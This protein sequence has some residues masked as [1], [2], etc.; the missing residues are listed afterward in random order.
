MFF[1]LS[2]VVSSFQLPNITA[3]EN[4]S[5]EVAVSDWQNYGMSTL[6]FAEDEEED[7]SDKGFYDYCSGNFQFTDF[8]LPHRFFS[9]DEE[10]KINFIENYFQS[11]L[12]P[13]F[14]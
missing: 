7:N 3:I 13:P 5:D 4:N 12:S 1:L 2:L 9:G 11:D 14:L 8:V 10:Q 6:L